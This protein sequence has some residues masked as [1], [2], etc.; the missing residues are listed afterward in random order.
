MKSIIALI[1][2][3][4]GLSQASGATLTCQITEGGAQKRETRV[5]HSYDESTPHNFTNFDSAYATGF[6]AVSRGYAVV[7]VVN[8]TTG[9]A[10]SF[11]GKA[12]PG[13]SIGG[14]LMLSDDGS[15]FFSVECL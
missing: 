15:D 7:N 10:T 6:V 8:K 11:Y 9:L 2:F 12:G 3:S 13:L 1:T 14:T 5:Q 4:I